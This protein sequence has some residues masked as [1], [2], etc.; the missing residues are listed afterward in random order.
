MQDL[1]IEGEKMLA[2]KALEHACGA[3]SATELQAVSKE[4]ERLRERADSVF[5]R[6]FGVPRRRSPT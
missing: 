4:V 5:E 6:A 1:L 2:N 3:A